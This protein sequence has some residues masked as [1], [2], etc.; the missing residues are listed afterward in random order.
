MHLILQ[1][2]FCWSLLRKLRYLWDGRHTLIALKVMPSLLFA[3]DVRGGRWWYGSRGWTFPPI[4]HYLL[5][6]CDRWQLRG[7]LTEQCLTWKHVWSRDVEWNS[8]MMEKPHPLTFI[9]ACWMFLETKQWMWAQWGDG[10]CVLGVVTMA[11][12]MTW[13]NKPHSGW[14][15]TAVTA[16][17]EEHLSQLICTNQLM[18]VTVLKN[19]VFIAE[20][21]SIK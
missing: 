7:S 15:C 6:L 10:W 3:H 17:N 20:I 5:L 21:C 1:N 12:E 2:Y 13:K 8:S 16:Q 9:N 14:P 4:F 19:S 11:W 18:V